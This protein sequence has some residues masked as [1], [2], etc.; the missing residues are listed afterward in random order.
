MS[1][2]V[3]FW[4]SRRCPVGKPAR[5]CPGE[6]LAEDS[7]A[8]RR[9]GRA[10]D[11]SSGSTAGRGTGSRWS[12]GAS[13]W[14]VVAVALFHARHGGP[15]DRNAGP[16]GQAAGAGPGGRE[17]ARGRRSVGRL[18]ASDG[19]ATTGVGH[20]SSGPPCHR[21]KRRV[22][23]QLGRDSSSSKAP[24]PPAPRLHLGPQPD[25]RPAQLQH[26][27]WEVGMATAPEADRLDVPAE[28]VQ[29]HQVLTPNQMVA[30]NLALPGRCAGGPRRKLPTVSN[31]TS[32]CDGRTWSSRRR[33][34]LPRW[35]GSVSSMPTSPRLGADLR[36]PHRVVLRISVRSLTSLMSTSIPTTSGPRPRKRGLT[37]RPSSL[38]A[39]RST[40]G[41]GSGHAE[42]ADKGLR[43]T[44]QGDR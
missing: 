10:R 33:S 21:R 25:H 23:A 38:P 35:I 17:A 27:R 8:G 31:A 44:T 15:R 24:C 16:T 22:G 13:R 19:G 39:W 7:P 20:A 3:G 40:G 1:V 5:V 30:Y 9:A 29:K 37:P 2:G 41:D 43:T 4:A 28:E 34:A 42:V 36:R 18:R 12:N 26:R 6:G 32:V 14:G 11:G